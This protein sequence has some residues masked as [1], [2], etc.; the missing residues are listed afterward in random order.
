MTRQLARASVSAVAVWTRLYTAGMEAE[1]RDRRRAEIE[2]DLWESQQ[3]PRPALRLALE[4]IARLVRGVPADLRWR[5]EHRQASLFEWFTVRF[6]G[7]T[8][9]ATLVVL[10]T[11]TPGQAYMPAAPAAPDLLGIRDRDTPPPPPPPP[12][13]PP[14][15]GLP[16][17][18]GCQPLSP[19]Q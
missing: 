12:C 8:A 17:Y 11:F 14:Q 13:P 2:S 18:P 1:L 3:E 9:I 16:D 7:A 10:A 6:V 4:L 5:S 19:R 15:N